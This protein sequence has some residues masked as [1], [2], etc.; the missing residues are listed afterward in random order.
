MTTVNVE[1]WPSDAGVAQRSFQLK[2]YNLRSIGYLSREVRSSGPVAQRFEVKLTLPPMGVIAREAEGNASAKASWRKVDGFLARLRGTSGFVRLRDHARPAPYYNIVNI[3]GVANWDDDATWDDGAQ[4]VGG[5]LPPYVVIDALARRGDNSVV[6]RGLPT[7]TEA[8]LNP[9]DLFEIRPNG[10][11]AEHGMLHLVTRQANSN[12]D[13]KSR[14]YFE[15]GIRLGVRS[16]DMVV[17][18]QPTSVF[19]LASDEDGMIDVDQALNGTLGLTLIE[20]LPRS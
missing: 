1:T 11:P 2:S 20:V 10:V 3:Q 17:L 7:S 6:M 4:W 13:G 16:G 18:R 9:G 19:S 12:S 8:A 14:V 5:H 15:P